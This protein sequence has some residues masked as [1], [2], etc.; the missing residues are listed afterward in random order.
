MHATAWFHD[1]IP[2]PILQK[3]DVV[4]HDPVA[5]HPTHGVFNPNADGSHMT[6]RGFLRGGEFS[7]RRFLLGLDH[8]DVRQAASLEAVILLQAAARWQRRPRQCCQALIR[9][10]AFRRVTQEAHGTR[11][12]AHAAVVEC[13]TR[14]LATVIVLWLGGIGWA[15]DW[16][17]GALM[18]TRGMGALPAGA[19]VSNIAA[20]SSAVRAGSSAWSA[21][22]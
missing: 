18:P 8:G 21:K 9:G 7:S 3:A 20:H 16:T 12:S 6:I 14:L 2:H 5:V 4:R 15:V 13:V 11:R 19:C 17:C 1:G 22:A 10:V